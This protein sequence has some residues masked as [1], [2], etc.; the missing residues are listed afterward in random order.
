LVLLTLIHWMFAYLV[1]GTH[2]LDK[3]SLLITWKLMDWKSSELQR[4][5]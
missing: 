2:P 5:K 1:D 3:Q 4:K